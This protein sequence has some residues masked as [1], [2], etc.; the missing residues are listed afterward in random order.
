M[1]KDKKKQIV[2]GLWVKR[3]TLWCNIMLMLQH[4]HHV[5]AECDA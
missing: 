5:A 1:V 3:V 4:Q 2:F